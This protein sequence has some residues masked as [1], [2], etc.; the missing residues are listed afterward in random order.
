VRHA[1]R[2]GKGSD[3]EVIATAEKRLLEKGKHLV[4]WVE[5]AIRV[6]KCKPLSKRGINEKRS[7]ILL[8]SG[9]QI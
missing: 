6:S 9:T 2:G 1:A 4:A 5:Q 3:I 8:Q 7:L